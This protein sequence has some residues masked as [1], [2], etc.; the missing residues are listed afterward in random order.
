MSHIL[1]VPGVSDTSRAMLKQL[2]DEDLIPVDA[3]P[4]IVESYRRVIHD[5][6]RRN[7]RANVRVG[8][9]IADAL[10][11][12]LRSVTPKTGD[13]NLRIIQAAVR[14]FVIQDNATEAGHDLQSERGL[15]DD[16]RVVNAVLRFLGRDDLMIPNIQAVN[17]Q[18]LPRAADAA[19]RS[20]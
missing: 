8:D 5:A 10:Q 9:Q 15:D 11:G 7:G 20:R 14:Y 16:A 3:L 18:P 4:H 19:R 17:D 6:H 1:R 2:L 13:K 12:L